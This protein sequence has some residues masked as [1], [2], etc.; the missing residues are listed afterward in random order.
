MADENT[1]TN[2]TLNTTTSNATTATS[3]SITVPDITPTSTKMITVKHQRR[4]KYKCKNCSKEVY[5]LGRHIKTSCPGVRYANHKI[6]FI[7]V[8]PP[9]YSFMQKMQMQE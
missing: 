8:K 2:T 3:A 6:C 1:T 4:K 7:E 5:H 9:D